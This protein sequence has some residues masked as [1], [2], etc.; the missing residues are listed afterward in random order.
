MYSDP[1]GP[2]FA[3]YRCRLCGFVPNL[4]FFIISLLDRSQGADIAMHVLKWNCTKICCILIFMNIIFLSHD[5]TNPWKGVWIPLYYFTLRKATIFFTWSFSCIYSVFLQL[6]KFMKFYC[7][8]I[9]I[10]TANVTEILASCSVVNFGTP[11]KGV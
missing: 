11:L 7:V 4:L 2:I 8:K 9:A 3:V 1:R 10:C 5:S 6:K